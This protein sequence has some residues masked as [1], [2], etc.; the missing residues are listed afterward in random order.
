MMLIAVVLDAMLMATSSMDTPRCRC[1]F[2]M[3]AFIDMTSSFAV[4]CHDAYIM[5]YFRRYVFS[6]DTLASMPTRFSAP[7]IYYFRCH[8]DA[9][10]VDL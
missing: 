1:R 10:D 2:L 3:F 9:I 8:A 5:P 4:S 6:A 7:L